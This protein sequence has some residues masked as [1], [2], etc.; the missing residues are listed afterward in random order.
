VI[1]ERNVAH[2]LLSGKDS[3]STALSFLQSEVSYGSLTAH[4]GQIAACLLQCGARQGDRVLLVGDNSL[5]WVACYL[6]TLQVGLVT[7]PIS[8]NSTAE[9]L[10]Y[11]LRTTG[12]KIVCVQD[13]V[14]TSHPSVFSGTHLIT[15]L[16]VLP[17][18][19]TLS[20][21]SFSSLRVEMSPLANHAPVGLNELAALVFT[22]GSTGR[23]RGVMI[24]H[25]NIVSN[26]ESII[27]YLSLN[28]QDRMM[29]VLPF[30]YC[31]GASLL[32]TH[33][34]V[35]GE[36]VVD[37]RFMYPETVLQR[38]IETKCT[39][40]AGVP[41]HF[42]ILL[43]KSSFKRKRFPDLRHVQQAGG[44][45]APIFV[46]ELQQILPDTMIYIMYGQTEATARLSY[47][48]PEMLETK[49]GSIGKGAPGVTLRV[50]DEQGRD[51]RP[52]EV[53]EIV[54]EGAN[55]AKGYWQ[56]PKESEMVF[57][58]GLLYTGDLA[59]VDEDGFLYIMDR[60]KDFL[61]CRG[62]KVSCRQIEEVLLECSE[63]VEAVVVGIPDDVLGEAL[64]V[65][66]VPRNRNT[67][68]L[69]E[70]VASFCRTRLALHHLP[71][72]IVILRSLPKNSAGKVMK[73]I[74]KV[75]DTG[76]AL[77]GSQDCESLLDEVPKYSS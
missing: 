17:I 24:T 57:R 50:L 63:I 59:R 68:G 36:V 22:S 55:I 3:A 31:Y 39:G 43:R 41:S 11:I 46:R 49:L 9:D 7:V 77:P 16:D 47:L 33:L 1:S 5:F 14:A 35:G 76:R 10:G 44:H 6:G 21:R 69:E 25:S 45:L 15:D 72:Q 61:K 18:A 34:R 26:T 8:A 73:G 13:S 20:Q 74:L 51:V 32:H 4:S 64:K 29:A 23:P 67:D 70:R 66:A 42:Q 56:E 52:G 38:M 40:F 48:P 27:S 19:E 12:A 75:H 30:H 62:E 71:K 60:T 58:N 65:F 53:G 37:N 2:Y 54:A 28:A